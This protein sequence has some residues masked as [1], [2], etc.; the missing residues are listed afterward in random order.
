MQA[1]QATQ[2][3]T[4]GAQCAGCF[5]VPLC[6]SAAVRGCLLPHTGLQSLLQLMACARVRG[7]LVM[8]M[9]GGAWPPSVAYKQVLESRS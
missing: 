2:E 4:S 8:H 9:L 3:T 1:T 5:A 7:R 6:R